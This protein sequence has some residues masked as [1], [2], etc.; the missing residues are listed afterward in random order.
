MGSRIQR[1]GPQRTR[2]YNR[3]YSG[4]GDTS[5]LP[6][7]VLCSFLVLCLCKRQGGVLTFFTPASKLAACGCCGDKLLGDIVFSWVILEL[8]GR[9]WCTVPPPPQGGNRHLV[10][11]PPGN[12]VPWGGA[13]HGGSGVE[14]HPTQQWWEAHQLSNNQVWISGH[15]NGLELV[16]HMLHKKPM[17]QQIPTL[18]II[19]IWKT[20]LWSS[21]SFCQGGNVSAPGI[22]LDLCPTDDLLGGALRG[23]T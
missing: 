4:L 10:T 5:V 12:R 18:T 20:Y 22:F 19:Q 1:S 2:P 9:E 7:Q 14:Q 8:A 21:I 3:R 11:V 23:R 6:S 17:A 13:G 15:P 16:K